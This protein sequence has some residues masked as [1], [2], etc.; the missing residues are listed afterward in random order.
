[1]EGT[2]SVTKIIAKTPAI[3]LQVEKIPELVF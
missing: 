2:N 3:I 1:M